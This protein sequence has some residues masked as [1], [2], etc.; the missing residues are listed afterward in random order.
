MYD[1]D[2]I[3]DLCSKFDLIE[4]VARTREVFHLSGRDYIICP[5]H[6]EKTPSL[7]LDDH[8]CYK[9]F[10]CGKH[11]DAIN[12]L[13]ETERLSFMNAVKKIA[14]ETHT[15]IRDVK[16]CEAMRYYKEVKRYQKSPDVQTY[17]PPEIPLE[18]IND[19]SDDVPKEWV[20]EG[21]SP[22]AIKKYGIRIDYRANR[23]VYPVYNSHFRLIGFKGRTRFE[24]YKDLGIAKYMNYQKLGAVDYFAGM[25]ENY[26]FV[27]E[28]K[29]A[30]VFEGLKS[31]MKLDDYGNRT[32]IAA[33]TCHL[34]EG[35]IRTLIKMGLKEITIAFD[36][37]VSLDL[38]K[39]CT[40]K[41]KKFMRIFV[42][43][44]RHSL[45]G[46]KEAPVD[47]GQEVW[48]QLFQERIIL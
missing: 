45:L 23:I 11:G 15:P 13:M 12:F 35:Q 2:V 14:D 40:A 7:L 41:L 6:K 38:I 4:Y 29:S 19:F 21:I 25:K 5:F 20:K 32:G 17:E 26:D 8:G 1:Q 30:V 36:S 34:S 9:C 16:Q 39:E 37:D 24:N 31:V 48:E 42:I 3:E 44:D 43:H 22:S 46:A 18:R 47:R 10:G 27:R 33:E 28:S